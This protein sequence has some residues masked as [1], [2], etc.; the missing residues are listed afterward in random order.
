MVGVVEDECGDSECADLVD[1]V[2]LDGAWFSSWGFGF[3]EADVSAGEEDEAVGDA[4]EAG[5]GE[6]PAVSSGGVDCADQGLLDSGFTH[7]APALWTDGQIDPN[8]A[9]KLYF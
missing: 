6:F 9:E 5:A 8:R 4:G 2:L 3:D 1:A 7:G